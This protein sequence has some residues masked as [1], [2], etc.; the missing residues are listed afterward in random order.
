MKIF[1]KTS[2]C[3]FLLLIITSH[4]IFAVEFEEKKPHDEKAILVPKGAR[5][6]LKEEYPRSQLVVDRIKARHSHPLVIPFRRSWNTAALTASTGTEMEENPEIGNN[7]EL[8]FALHSQRLRVGSTGN[9]QYFQQETEGFP[10]S[11][12]WPLPF[13]DY[14]DRPKAY[15]SS[16]FVHLAAK[17]THNMYAEYRDFSDR[18]TGILNAMMTDNKQLTIMAQ[19]DMQNLRAEEIGTLP[20]VRNVAG[21]SYKRQGGETNKLELDGSSTWSTL[22]DSAGRDFRY[23]SGTGV[24][25]WGRQMRPD[26][27]VDVRTQMQ[28]STVKDRNSEDEEPWNV[29]KTGSLGLINTVS[30][31]EF[32]RLRLNIS[33]LYD[34]EHKAFFTP[35]VELAITPRIIEASVGFRR[36]AILPDHDEIYFPS[37]FVKVNED[38][39]AESFWEAYGSLNVDI[40]TR[41]K[42]IAEA[43]YSRPE[44]RITWVQHTGYVWEPVNAETSQAMKGEAYLTLNLIGDLGIFG[45]VRY[46]HF[47]NQLNDPEVAASGGISY[48][49]PTSGSITL[50]AAF[51]NFKPLEDTDVPEDFVFAYLRINKSIRRVVNIFIDGRYSPD[52]EYIASYRG[53][54]Q[55]GRIIS[56]GANIIFGGLD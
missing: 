40:I 20:R 11:W 37:K 16:T 49:R 14:V 39:K 32:V 2:F 18:I 21:I 43:S 3:A 47:D 55:A 31:S 44:S 23:I 13:I 33:A 38:L 50:G 19:R 36:A 53:T 48:G 56:V 27:N 30:P 1:R 9:R 4:Q 12:Y 51:W 25:V 17:R 7:F 45:S 46:Q 15:M 26:F 41:L 24:V 34:S 28:V 22:A 35:G 10:Q 6:A 42:L 54:P 5:P 8:G 29:R 52:Q